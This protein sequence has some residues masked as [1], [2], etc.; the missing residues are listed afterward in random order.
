MSMCVY[1]VCV[2]RGVKVQM[3]V[4]PKEYCTSRS[5]LNWLSVIPSGNEFLASMFK[6]SDCKH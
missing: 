3:A 2:G 5:R 6:Q 4:E 1:Y